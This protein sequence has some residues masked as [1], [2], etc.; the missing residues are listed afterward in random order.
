[1][2]GLGL[3]RRVVGRRECPTW[4]WLTMV[5]DGTAVGCSTRVDVVEVV[6]GCR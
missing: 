1:M 6:G 4:S 2:F 5:Q 3:D